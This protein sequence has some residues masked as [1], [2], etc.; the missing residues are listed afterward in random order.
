MGPRPLYGTHRFNRRNCFPSLPARSVSACHRSRPLDLQG[1]I[2]SFPEV[3][4]ALS[5]KLYNLDHDISRAGDT[6]IPCS[7]IDPPKSSTN[8]PFFSRLPPDPSSS[9]QICAPL[10][11]HS[12]FSRSMP[13]YYRKFSDRVLKSHVLVTR[14][15]VEIHARYNTV[16][17]SQRYEQDSVGIPH[18]HPIG[19]PMRLI[20]K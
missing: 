5:E 4:R 20:P 15:M 7:P 8:P 12:T 2:R 14:T 6:Q 18:T 16:G 9:A 10:T 13:T 11:I 19:S 17:Q 3:I 1:L